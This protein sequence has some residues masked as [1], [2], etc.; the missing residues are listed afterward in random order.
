MNKSPNHQAAACENFIDTKVD[1]S[2][3][4]SVLLVV[5]EI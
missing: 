3:C 5:V 1:A 2:A 4:Y